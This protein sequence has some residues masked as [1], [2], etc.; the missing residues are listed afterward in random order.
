MF[1]WIVIAYFINIK[2]EGEKM[3]WCRFMEEKGGPWRRGI[4]DR[5]IGRRA[6]GGIEEEG[7][8]DKGV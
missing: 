8:R 3:R 7:E 4:R 2:N 1:G 5:G 6:G